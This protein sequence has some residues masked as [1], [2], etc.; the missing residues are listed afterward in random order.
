[1]GTLNADGLRNWW[2]GRRYQLLAPI[3]RGGASTVFRGID[4]R[5]ARPVAVKVVDL[6]D[7]RPRDIR[8]FAAEARVLGGLAHPGLVALL[9]VGADLGP[10]HEPL[11]YLVMELVEGVT[12]ATMLDRGP[13]GPNQAADVGQ[14]LAQALEHAHA[15]GIV[16]RDVK[17]A[18][19]LL[20]AEPVVSGYV[21][22]PTVTTKLADFGIAVGPT[23]VLDEHTMSDR[24][25][26]TASYLSPEQALAQP[27]GPASDVY[28]LGLVLLE[29]LTGVR[30]YPGGALSS[31]L[32]R[33]LDTPDVPDR[34][35]PRW[36]A[37][38]RAMTTMAPESRPTASDVA[39]SLRQLRRPALWDR[40]AARLD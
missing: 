24:T 33:L 16:H 5:L 38:L 13:L 10:A 17:P 34:L 14:Q 20:S 37:L 32:A 7:V 2:L 23:A 40:V 1:M 8:R 21:A 9:D 39:E 30:A 4:E 27:L 28:S 31:S 15:A 6:A 12:L 11:A 36:S 35:G 18:N 26:G 29:S 3:G 19:I 22:G 25:R